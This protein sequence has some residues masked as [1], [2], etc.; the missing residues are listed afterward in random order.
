MLRRNVAVKLLYKR[1]ICVCG[2]RWR[3]RRSRTSAEEVVEAWKKGVK[4]D[5]E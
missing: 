3:R 1:I 4:N 2:A 5:S